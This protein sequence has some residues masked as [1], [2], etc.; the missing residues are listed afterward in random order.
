MRVLIVGGAGYIGGAMTDLLIDTKHDVRIYD[1]L[2]YEEAYR[3]PVEFVYGDILDRQKLKKHL[4]WA[5]AVIWLAALVG[6]GACA[7]NPTLSIDINQNSVEWL[8]K[9]YDGRIIFM[10]TCSVYGAQDGELTE[11]SP[12]NPLSVYAM[13]KLAAEAFLENKNALIFRLGTIFGVGI[14]SP[15]CAWIWW[16]MS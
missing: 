8:S 16:L 14:F 11:D 5:D 13:T 9:N 10:S 1:S 4:A 6:D 7:L 15:G 3:K 12:K 2:V